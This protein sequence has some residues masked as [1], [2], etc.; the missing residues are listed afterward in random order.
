VAYLRGDS[1][2][3][4][5][6]YTQLLANDR[7]VL[8]PDHPE[9]AAT[10]MNIGR[11]RL[12]RRDFAGAIAI[13]DAAINIMLAQRDDTRDSFAFAFSN[14]ALAYMGIADYGRAEPLFTKALHAAVI[15]NHRTHAPILT[16]LADLE[17]RTKRYEAGLARLEEARP[18]MAERYPDDPWRVA[19]IDNVEGGC[20]MGLGRVNEAE[21]LLTR[22]AAIMLEK[23][24]PNTLYGYDVKKRMAR[25]QTLKA[26]QQG[27]L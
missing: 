13:L 23:W 10:M 22:S 15:N 2:K 20:L 27:R 18:I 19:L 1:R 26:K 12:E 4:E 14:I 17:C 6:L 5:L 3:A 16:D 8:G 21:P 9:L 11:L 24:Q 25:L 7:K